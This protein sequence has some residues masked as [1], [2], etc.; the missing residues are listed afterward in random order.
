MTMGSQDGSTCIDLG[1]CSKSFSM[2]SHQKISHLQTSGKCTWC[3]LFPLFLGQSG[4]GIL[5][6]ED[7]TI[8]WWILWPHLV[9]QMFVFGG[10][11]P[12]GHGRM[13][14]KPLQKWILSLLWTRSTCMNRRCSGLQPIPS[15]WSVLNKPPISQIE[16][17]GRC[18]I[19]FRGLLLNTLTMLLNCDYVPVVE[20]KHWWKEFIFSMFKMVI[21]STTPSTSDLVTWPATQGR[22]LLS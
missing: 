8:G 22:K 14:T 21:P 15:Q 10:H 16:S 6:K 17:L 12:W 11:C 13:C 20:V 19:P 2:G 9:F 4:T 7:I 18:S 3:I 5:T 1:C